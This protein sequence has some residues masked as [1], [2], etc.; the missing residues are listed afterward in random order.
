MAAQKPLDVP[1]VPMED[2]PNPEEALKREKLTGARH[3]AAFSALGSALITGSVLAVT[4]IGLT[5]CVAVCA[6]G[7][8]S[9]I[10]AIELYRRSR[11]RRREAAKDPRALLVLRYAQYYLK[12][13]KAVPLE[14]ACSGDD[15]IKQV[16]QRVFRERAPGV[17]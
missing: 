5:A 7:A 15:P 14:A 3:V 10:S 17:F 9:I 8:F 12:N 6:L 11:A 2:L 16:A 4:V 1:P 13:P